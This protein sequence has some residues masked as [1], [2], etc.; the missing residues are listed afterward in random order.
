M[1]YALHA[2]YEKMHKSSHKGP[3]M[4]DHLHVDKIKLGSSESQS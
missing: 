4:E 1:W 2:Y 3:T